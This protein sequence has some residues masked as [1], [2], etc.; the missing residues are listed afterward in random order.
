MSNG[1]CLKEKFIN[2]GLEQGYCYPH[3]Y[4][5]KTVFSKK[6]KFLQI[7]KKLDTT[8]QLKCCF[9]LM[10]WCLFRGIKFFCRNIFMNLQKQLKNVTSVNKQIYFSEE[11]SIWSNLNFVWIHIYVHTTKIFLYDSVLEQVGKIHF[12]ELCHISIVRQ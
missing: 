12:R 7:N 4:L 5:I 11:I 10:A 6:W 8:Y 3:Y 2:R 1:H 9:L